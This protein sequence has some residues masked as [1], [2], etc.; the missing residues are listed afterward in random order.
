M[1]NFVGVVFWTDDN[2]LQRH[3]TERLK[4]AVACPDHRRPVVLSASPLH[5][6]FGQKVA[7]PEDHWE[8]Q[9]AST[10]DIVSLFD[11]RMD[12]REELADR[13]AL[14]LSG[15]PD[16]DLALMAYRRWGADAP[17]EVLGEFAWAVW[18]GAERRLVLA[19]DLSASRALYVFS[20][21]RFV[22]FATGLRA[23][24]SLPDVPREV[25]DQGLAEFIALYPGQGERT[26]Y[27]NVVRV[28]PG[29]TLIIDKNGLRRTG[30]WKPRPVQAPRDPMACADAAREVFGRAVR[31][32]LRAIGP[33][34]ISLSGGLDSSIVAAEAARQRAP[35][36]VLGFALV[37]PAGVPLS[38]PEGWA[39]DDRPRVEALARAHPNLRVE[40]IEPSA[41][42]ID[43]D[44]TA[45][46]VATCQPI[47]L[48]PNIGWLLTA[49]RAAH[50]SGAR[51]LLTGDDG[52]MSLTHYGSLRAVARQGDVW[53]ALREAWR[54]SRR[55]RGGFLGLVD[56]AFLGGHW[57][58]LRHGERGTWSGNWQRITPIHPD[59]AESAGVRE[60]L[61]S[62]KFPGG[63]Q[64]QPPGYAELL[65]IYRRWRA[66][67][68]ETVAAMR[69]LSGLDYTCPFTDRRVLEFCLSLPEAMFVRDGRTR[70]L[71]RAA[72]RT[73]LPPEVRDNVTKGA[74]NPEWFHHLTL[75]RGALREQLERIESSP[76]ASRALDVPRLK[77]LLDRWPASAEEAE[78]AGPAY[79]S[80]LARGLHAGAFLHWLDPGNGG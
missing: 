64:Y 59:L 39:A 23:L 67:T 2:H 48:S 22:A 79:R 53:H 42:P 77:A 15:V 57:T 74:Q 19:R 8:R 62:E 75:R 46:F 37:P 29:T 70:W 50:A 38:V 43:A 27:R 55:Q 47:G 54:I 26:I 76:L 9:P 17:Q 36:A 71:A 45:L 31:S 18:D 51:V 10:G 66:P 20:T 28:M 21:D 11:G 65:E 69:H 44:P 72:F 1:S 33:T 73:L 6:A 7:T 34:A 35:N 63:L 68:I 24:F 80:V 49:W 56:R 13:L 58:R 52:E 25:D 78:A 32:R 16:G 61:L 4:A 30:N 12:D 14:S 41:A 40:F 5:V 60:L 3:D